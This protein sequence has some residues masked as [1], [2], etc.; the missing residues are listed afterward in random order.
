[1]TPNQP[2]MAPRP[3]QP[4]AA[5]PPAPGPEQPAPGNEAGKPRALYRMFR[6]LAPSERNRRPKPE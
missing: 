4:P 6:K 5:R 3:A 2:P 1:M